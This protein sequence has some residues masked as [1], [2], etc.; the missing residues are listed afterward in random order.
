MHKQW[1]HLK[2]KRMINIKWRTYI[3]FVFWL[4]ASVACRFVRERERDWKRRE[5]EWVSSDCAYEIICQLTWNR[6]KQYSGN[7]LLFSSVLQSRIIGLGWAC[8]RILS[9]NCKSPDIRERNLNCVE[10]V[11]AVVWFCL[12]V[13]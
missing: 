6:W 5:K 9:R 13:V 12:L 4:T 3:S 2:N 11:Y 10:C 1:F 7:I 8:W